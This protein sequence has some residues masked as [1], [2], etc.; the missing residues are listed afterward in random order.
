MTEILAG[1]IVAGYAAN[2]KRERGLQPDEL[3]I[4]SPDIGPPYE[5]PPLSKDV[6]ARK[7]AGSI[8]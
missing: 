1:G 4:V 2:E 5:R 8:S 7:A 6:L 3:A